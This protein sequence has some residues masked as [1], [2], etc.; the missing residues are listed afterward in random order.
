METFLRIVSGVTRTFYYPLTDEDAAW[1]HARYPRR[2]YD[3][4]NKVAHADQF[5]SYPEQWPLVVLF[6]DTIL[7]IDRLWGITEGIAQRA[8]EGKL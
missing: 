2:F 4:A 7:R 6:E 1:G 3:D 5:K 8:R